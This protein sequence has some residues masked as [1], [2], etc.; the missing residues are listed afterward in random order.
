M[1]L[2]ILLFFATPREPRYKYYLAGLESTM[3]LPTLPPYN[4]L[5]LAYYLS[6]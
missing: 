1:N 2:Y 3:A 4:L 5:P 6:I